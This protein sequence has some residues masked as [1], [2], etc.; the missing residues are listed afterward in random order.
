MLEM[1][2]AEVT[3]MATILITVVVSMIMIKKTEPIGVAVIALLIILAFLFIIYLPVSNMANRIK[4]SKTEYEICNLKSEKGRIK[5]QIKKENE[6]ITISDYEIVADP[7]V[8]TPKVVEI[9]KRKMI[10]LLS[11]DIFWEKTETYTLVVPILNDNKNQ[12]PF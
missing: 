5:V 12:K 10:S 1:G 3:L 7:K 4:T 11:K 8:K 6:I 2:L 9:E